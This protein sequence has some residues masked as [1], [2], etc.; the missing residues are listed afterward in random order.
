M[1]PN[2][3]AAVLLAGVLA[4]P[5]PSQ[6]N[7][8]VRPRTATVV[9]TSAAPGEQVAFG[10]AMTRP[11][12]AIP[13]H[14]LFVA[15]TRVVDSTARLELFRSGD[16]GLNWRRAAIVG[17]QS[18]G[19]GSLLVDG[20]RLFLA[21]SG[22][23]SR[24]FG[25]IFVQRFE[26][27]DESFVGE[28][29]E[30]VSGSGAEDQYFSPDCECTADGT[31]VV[32]VGSHRN[33]PPPW[34]CGWSSGIFVLR[35]DAKEWQGPLQFNAGSYGLWGN[36][37]AIGDVVHASYR[38]TI[39]AAA[40]GSRGYD[41]VKGAF[42]TDSERRVSASGSQV[43]NSCVICAD[44]RGGLSVIFVAGA[45]EPGKGRLVVGY[46]PGTDQPF[47]VQPLVDD[48][49]LIAGNENPTHF[50][51]SRGP[52]DQVTAVYSKASEQFAH[53]YTRIVAEGV[54]MTAEHRVVE[55]EPGR[56]RI[57]HGLRSTQVETGVIALGNG[58]T[59]DALGGVITLHGVL[60]SRVTMRRGRGE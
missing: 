53:L 15:V 4:I 16:G 31:L 8:S 45:T 60:P 25:S 41:V 11:F 24:G 22:T 17:A 50:A 7:R 28:P 35:P 13:G 12:A 14:G 9:I 29:Y 46:S 37:Q 40:I 44:D 57:V 32:M 18:A 33:P 6:G 47:T 10:S 51:L 23:G 27:R 30:L 39:D 49:S 5:A 36:L 34:T 20:E 58:P 52:G 56:F 55:G 19:E 43:A 21:W 2:V 3:V 1:R 59:K 26:P 38:T 42:T 48:P 54:P